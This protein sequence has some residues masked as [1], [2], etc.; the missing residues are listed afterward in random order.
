MHDKNTFI[1]LFLLNDKHHDIY[2]IFTCFSIHHI[3][4]VLIQT[5]QGQGKHLRH[6]WR[7]EEVYSNLFWNEVEWLHNKSTINTALLAWLFMITGKEKGR[8]F[9]HFS[10]W[11]DHSFIIY[12]LTL[13]MVAEKLSNVSIWVRWVRWFFF[14]PEICR[15]F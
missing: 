13:G 15:I 5:S 3:Y 11:I 8:K 12:L 14:S 2:R 6:V 10:S 9:Y 4:R 7:I 1:S